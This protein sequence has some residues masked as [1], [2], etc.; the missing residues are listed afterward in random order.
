MSAINPYIGFNGRCR[1]AM[2][3]Y[4]DI[5]G[6]TLDLNE[7]GGSPMEQ[8]WPSGAKDAIY[9][10]ELKSGGIV[11]MGSD[12]AG[13]GE[14]ITGTNISVAVG[15]DSEADIHNFFNKLA[16]GGEVYEPVREQFWGALFA[17]VKDKF[18]I[19]WMLTYDKNQQ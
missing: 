1:E 3:F 2:N 9:H 11:I 14:Q 17:A 7:V 15:C 8:Y 13:P 5:F 18:G 19:R 4:K 10:S 12:M 16:E 6:G